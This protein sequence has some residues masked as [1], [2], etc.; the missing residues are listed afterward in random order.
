[1]TTESAPTDRDA[2]PS[3]RIV[4]GT[5]GSSGADAA[6]V[7]AA[8]QSLSSGS[9]LQLVTSFGTGYA[10]VTPSD[11]QSATDK[12]LDEAASVAEQAAAGVT[13]TRKAGAGQPDAVLIDAAVG[14]DLL[15]VG[16]RGLGG[17]KGRLL[18]SVSRRCVHRSPC[19]VVVVKEPG[20]EDVATRGADGPRIVVGIDG[21]PSSIA[22]A[23]WAADQ[24]ERSGAVVD[25]VMA[26]E[27]PTSYGSSLPIPSD[28]D[29]ALDNN[30][31]LAASLVPVR[32]AHPGVTFRPSVIEGHPSRVLEQSADGADLLVVGNR[33]HGEFT[34]M[35]IGSVSE[36]C[37]S[38][39]RC[40]VLV[41]RD[42]HDDDS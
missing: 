11:A 38:H 33:G 20:D 30:A 15:V 9:V 42:R 21:S 8:V 28:W 26:W 22:A 19:P 17:F 39:A 5:D 35:L 7:W 24:A 14:A 4:V 18:G 3:R 31:L 25:A 32:D 37:V 23:A 13:V 2:T 36:H 16:S 29:P 40:P 1:M 34:G 10:L 41:F 27:L 6:V 12:V